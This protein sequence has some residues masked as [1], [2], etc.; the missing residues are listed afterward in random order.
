MATVVEK[1]VNVS[2]RTQKNDKMEFSG[3]KLNFQYSFEEGK[4]VNEIQVTGSKTSNTEVT[5]IPFMSYS[6]MG[7]NTNISIPDAVFDLDLLA[8]IKMEIDKI[9]EFK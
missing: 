8:T 1:R 3:W 5:P 7:E 9:S 2:T 4:Q 6:K